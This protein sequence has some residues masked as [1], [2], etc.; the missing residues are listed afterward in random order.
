[1][2]LIV[3]HKTAISKLCKEHHVKNLYAFGSVITQGFSSKSDIDLIVEFEPL[4][5]EVGAYLDKRLGNPPRVAVPSR[6]D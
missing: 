5:E 2:K 6:R 3:Q 1:M 4:I